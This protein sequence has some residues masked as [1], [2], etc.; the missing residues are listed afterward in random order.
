MAE[1]RLHLKSFKRQM[2]AKALGPRLLQ[3]SRTEGTPSGH[4]PHLKGI[5]YEKQFKFDKRN[6]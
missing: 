5:L 2:K 1:R 4:G 3:I 6:N